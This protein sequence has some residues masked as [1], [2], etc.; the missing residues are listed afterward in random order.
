MPLHGI[1]TLVLSHYLYS[2]ARALSL[3]SPSRAS[4]AIVLSRY[5]CYRTRALSLLPSR[6]F[7]AMRANF[8]V[9]RAKLSLPYAQIFLAM[10][11]NFPCHTRKPFL[12]I[13]ANLFLSNLTGITTMLTTTLPRNGVTYQCS[14]DTPE[15]VMHAPFGVTY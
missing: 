6:S 15:L 8:L 11:A 14:P 10:S 12:A 3:L 9:M 1:L 2:R 13:R 7:V 5:F 4:F